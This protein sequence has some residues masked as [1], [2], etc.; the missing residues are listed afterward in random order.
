MKI[1]RKLPSDPTI[2]EQINLLKREV[3]IN[4][5]DFKKGTKGI[6]VSLLQKGK[7]WVLLDNSYQTKEGYWSKKR[8]FKPNELKLLD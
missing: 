6:I 2:D 8:Q 3:L 1:A 7:Y 5:D 4:C